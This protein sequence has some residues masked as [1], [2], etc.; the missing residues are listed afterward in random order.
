MDAWNRFATILPA[1][2][3]YSLHLEYASI[4]YD[5]ISDEKSS[6]IEKIQRRAIIAYTRAYQRGGGHAIDQISDIRPPK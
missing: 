4:C 2:L 3:L 5:S 6:Q 1:K